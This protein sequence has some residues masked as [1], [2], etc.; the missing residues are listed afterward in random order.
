LKNYYH[1]LGV[2]PQSDA[3]QI[4]MAYRRLAKRYHP[5]KN[6]GGDAGSMILSINEAYEVLGDPVRRKRYDTER[7]YFSQTTIKS[8]SSPAKRKSRPAPVRKKETESPTAFLALEY[9]LFA[10]LMVIGLTG[11]YMAVNDWFV[12]GYQPS[13]T[14][15]GL[16]FGIL[17]TGLLAYTMW[18]WH[19]RRK[20]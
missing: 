15:S 12:H 9:V 2:S 7:L 18:M 11:L 5:D 8:N 10:V 3:A 13:H 4:K 17:F 14:A 19:K 16:V 20:P 1:I 6:P